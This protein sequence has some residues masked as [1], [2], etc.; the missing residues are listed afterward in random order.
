MPAILR[1]HCVDGFL[2]FGDWEPTDHLAGVIRKL[3]LPQVAVG[4]KDDV[5]SIYPGEADAC[6]RATERLI[7]AGHTHIAHVPDD[8][9]P[10]YAQ[11]ERRTGYEASMAAAGLQAESVTLPSEYR[12]VEV[13]PW[14]E[15]SRQRQEYLTSP[16]RATALVVDSVELAYPLLADAWRAGLTL[17]NDLAMITFHDVAAS[18]LGICIDTMLLRCSELG[19]TAVELLQKRISEQKPQPA[20]CLE[21]EYSG[22]HTV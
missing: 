1:E 12:R 19:S 8:R 11:R 14:E 4:V 6:R 10:H 18:A 7:A 9:L 5:D 20:V 17:P 16:H 22:G 13:R 3:K 21:Y 2:L 15:S